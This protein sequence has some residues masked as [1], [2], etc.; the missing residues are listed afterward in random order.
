MTSNPVIVLPLTSAA[1]LRRS[2]RQRG[3]LSDC[4][5]RNDCRRKALPRIRPDITAMTYRHLLLALL[6]LVALSCTQPDTRQGYLDEAVAYLWQMQGQDG[7][8]H[9]ETH[10]I[11]KGGEALTPF[12]LYTLLQAQDHVSE[13]VMDKQGIE[14]AF[15]FI[16]GHV[17]EEGVLGLSNPAVMEYPN[18]ATAYALRALLH[19]DNDADRPLIERMVTYLVGQQWKESRAIDATHVAYGGWGFGEVGLP[20]GQVGYVDLSHTRRVLQALQAFYARYPDHTDAYAFIPPVLTFLDH[21]QKAS[22]THYDGGFFY[23]PVVFLANKGRVLD[24]DTPTYGSYATATCDGLLA[25]L[26]AGL[27]TDTARM[28]DAWHWLQQHAELSY[29]E[30]IPQN[31]PAQWHRVMYFYHLA[32]RAEVFHHFLWPEGAHELLCSRCSPLTATSTAPML[33]HTVPRTKK[34][35]RSWQQHLPC[36]CWCTWIPPPI[37]YCH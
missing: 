32:V 25:L 23:S 11:L 27:S 26:S 34:M 21:M 30:G 10:G 28:A 6:P 9:S 8:W 14:E 22:S 31:T 2:R 5:E 3:S 37:R 1:F 7:G 35:I 33:I 24:A 15:Q 19:G 4:P 16:R 12:I 17:N 13:G 36:R 29:A 18:Y 20:P